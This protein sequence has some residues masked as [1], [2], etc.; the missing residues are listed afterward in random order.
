VQLLTRCDWRDVSMECDLL[1]LLP[2]DA[3]FTVT[4]DN[5]TYWFR[6]DATGRLHQISAIPFDE[7]C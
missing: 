3:V 7:L 2:Y 1:M 6:A 4:L 5:T